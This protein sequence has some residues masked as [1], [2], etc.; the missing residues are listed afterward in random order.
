MTSQSDGGQFNAIV[1]AMIGKASVAITGQG[2][3]DKTAGIVRGRYEISN[4]P[5]TVHPI[6]STAFCSQDI[7][8]FA[9]PTQA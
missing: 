4:L 3:F 1:S 8:R 2:I 6:Y 9:Q 7:L 5:S